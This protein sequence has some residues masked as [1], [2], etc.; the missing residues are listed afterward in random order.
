MPLSPVKHVSP[1][2][3]NA[4]LDSISPQHAPSFVNYFPG[5]LFVTSNAH[6]PPIFIQALLCLLSTSLCNRVSSLCNRP[7][8]LCR[9]AF[10]HSVFWSFSGELSVTPG[11]AT[12]RRKCSEN[13]SGKKIYSHYLNSSGPDIICLSGS[14]YIYV[15]H[16]HVPRPKRSI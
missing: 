14:I 4:S 3:G 2:R 13:F 16:L 11:W 5:V 7:S 9:A 8:L 12:V 1:R 6:T 15:P 10:P